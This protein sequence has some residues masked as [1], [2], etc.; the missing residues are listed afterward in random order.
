EIDESLRDLYK[1]FV[2]YYTAERHGG[3]GKTSFR[4]FLEGRGNH[5]Y[6]A[7]V[8]VLELLAEKDFGDQTAQQRKDALT[9]LAE[10]SKKLRADHRKIELTA[11]M[12]HAEKTGDQSKIRE[13]EDEMKTLSS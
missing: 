1:D 4:I 10:E 6:A 3:S 8:A 9:R 13:I 11:A 12:A 5:E 7:K 2:A